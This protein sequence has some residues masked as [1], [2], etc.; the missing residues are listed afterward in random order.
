MWEMGVHMI[1]RAM[2]IGSK[3]CMGGCEQFTF[4]KLRPVSHVLPPALEAVEVRTACASVLCGFRLVAIGALQL[5]GLRDLGHG[6]ADSFCPSS[7][8]SASAMTPHQQK[9]NLPS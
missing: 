9:R 8:E 2:S 7:Q 1:Q 6:R 3:Q 5:A 4:A